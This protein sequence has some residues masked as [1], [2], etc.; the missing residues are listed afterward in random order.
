MNKIQLTLVLGAVIGGIVGLIINV[1]FHMS[2]NFIIRTLLY[3]FLSG[4]YGFIIG[5]IR[6]KV[7]KTDIKNKYISLGIFSLSVTGLYFVINFIGGYCIRI[8]QNLWYFYAISLSEYFFEE[9]SIGLIYSLSIG[10]IS[11]VILLVCNKYFKLEIPYFV[12]ENNHVK[13]FKESILIKNSSTILSLL[14][15]LIFQFITLIGS[16][17][18]VLLYAI[19]KTDNGIIYLIFIII[20]F[21]ICG[22]ILCLLLKRILKINILLSIFIMVLNPI[23]IFL[24]Q[25]IVHVNILEIFWKGISSLY[26]NHEIIY[27][28]FFNLPFSLIVMP[29]SFF[30]TYNYLLNREKNK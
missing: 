2:E 24:S 25:Y 10:A 12:I 7:F 14:I 15:I 20:W 18:V 23:I 21:L 16:P 22:I 19:I 13:N 5:K 11:F 4:S 30:L 9:F 1:I 6:N 29:I 28:I 27:F 8:I 3:I 26:G 17:V